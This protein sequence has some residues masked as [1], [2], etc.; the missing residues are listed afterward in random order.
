MKNTL[1]ALA[2]YIPLSV[3]ALVT[4][5]PFAYL[6]CSAFKRPEAFF[7][8][9]FLPLTAEGGID[10]G[11]MTFDNFTRLFTQTT[12]GYALANSFFF[13]S[14]TSVL[15]TLF[16]AMGGFAL[17]KYRFPGRSLTMLLIIFTLVV[18]NA[19][20][21]APGYRVIYWLGMID[22]YSGVI[23]PIV[24]PAFG[25]F[26]FRQ[27]ISAGVPDEML[28]AA[29]IDGASEFR[30]F[31]AMVL[32]LVR[33]MLGAFVMI[34]YL[35]VW[36]AYLMPQIVLQSPTN[37]PLA[38]MIAQMRGVYV[39]EYGML[40]AGTLVAIL[41]VLLLFLLLQRDFIAGLT[42]GAVKG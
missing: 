34:T 35:T 10:W 18:P 19:L 8:S 16:S 41:P 23:L 13:A 22:S 1:R 31:F 4:L 5:V 24:V 28:D 27:A 32:P 2:I 25:V 15:A 40:M 6:I 38:V 26:L 20:L 3:F 33:P 30:V 21:I 12:I 9:P 14:V 42:S 11:G 7:S 37:H 39:T 17:A 29:R 36:N